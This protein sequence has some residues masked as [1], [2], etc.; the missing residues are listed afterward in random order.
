MTTHTFD[1]S[2]TLDAVDPMVLTLRSKVEGMLSDDTRF[3]FEIG[4]TEIL[5]NLV[6]HAQTDVTDPLIKIVLTV[7]QGIALIDISDPSGAE[8][9]DLRSHATD[10]SDID[11]MAEGGRGL[12]LIVQCADALHYDQSGDQNH[13]SLKFCDDDQSEKHSS[14]MNGANE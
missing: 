14:S 9:F 8:P 10:L 7:K 13:L 5:T 4:V 12:G 2:N 1:I 11:A 3:R 6:N